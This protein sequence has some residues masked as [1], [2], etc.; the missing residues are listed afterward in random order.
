[1]ISLF[2]ENITWKIQRGRSWEHND[3]KR[4]KSTVVHLKTY[5][6]SPSATFGWSSPS[7]NKP[8]VIPRREWGFICFMSLAGRQSSWM[9]YL[10][11]GE[12]QTLNFSAVVTELY[13]LFPCYFWSAPR[14]VGWKRLTWFL[15]HHFH[16]AW[17][18]G[19]CMEPALRVSLNNVWKRR[20]K[21]QKPFCCFSD[22]TFPADFSVF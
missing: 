16:A 5:L 4:M 15:W 20:R 3:R 6:W 8:T 9:P 14:S 13:L 17:G 21:D 19:T 11:S 1:M 18:K 7:T 12:N 2:L 22:Q 10:F